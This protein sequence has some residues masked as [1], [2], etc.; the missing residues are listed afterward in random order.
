MLCVIMCDYV[1]VPKPNQ[2]F[3]WS[4]VISENSFICETAEL[5]NLNQ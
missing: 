4:G 1:F 2:T 5:S 3:T